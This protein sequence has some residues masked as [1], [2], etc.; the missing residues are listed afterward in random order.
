MLKGLPLLAAFLTATSA[1]AGALQGLSLSAVSQTVRKAQPV[2]QGNCIHQSCMLGALEILKD[3]L[4]DSIKALTAAAATAPSTPVGARDVDRDDLV[5]QL[6][7]IKG[8]MGR[9][10]DESK[11]PDFERDL[12]ILG[13]EFNGDGDNFRNA[14]K[15]KYAELVGKRC[16]SIPQSDAAAYAECKSHIVVLSEPNKDE[17]MRYIRWVKPG[18]GNSL[19]YIG[20]GIEDAI[21]IGKKDPVL[22]REW[23]PSLKISYEE[24]T[25]LNQGMLYTRD[26]D[27]VVSDLARFLKPGAPINLLACNTGQ[28]F[29]PHLQAGVADAAVSASVTGMHFEYRLSNG[30]QVPVDHFHS[31]PEGAKVIMVGR[32]KNDYGRVEADPTAGG[33]ALAPPAKPSS[34]NPADRIAQDVL[35]RIAVNSGDKGVVEGRMV[36][37]TPSEQDTVLGVLNQGSVPRISHRDYVHGQEITRESANSIFENAIRAARPDE[38]PRLQSIW[39]RLQSM[40]QESEKYYDMTPPTKQASR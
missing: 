12:I 39:T 29:A 34:L 2:F 40:M 35:L 6:I 31:P 23:D 22:P 5:A 4:E 7:T 20:H 1:F 28:R 13:H 33:P 36:T 27:S 30:Q 8:Q 26:L 9:C 14:L 38:K 37:F 3:N 21:V 32:G 24:W 25:K 15:T 11:G 19:T 10:E 16:G 17:L 18:T